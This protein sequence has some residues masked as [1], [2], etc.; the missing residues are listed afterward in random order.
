MNKLAEQ[1]ATFTEEEFRVFDEWLHIHIET[2]VDCG[3]IKEY[4]ERDAFTRA[5]NKLGWNEKKW[6]ED[7]E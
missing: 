6:W 1:I 2:A 5:I 3:I 7:E 4:D